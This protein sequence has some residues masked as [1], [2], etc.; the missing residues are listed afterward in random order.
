MGRIND[1]R[2][3]HKRLLVPSESMSLSRMSNSCHGRRVPWWALCLCL[4]VCLA[5]IFDRDLWTPDEPR[6]AAIS[7]EMS[8]TGNL[9]VPYLAGEPF[10]EK[11][12]LYFAIA[13]GF[14]RIL[15]PL[16]GNTGAIRLTSALWGLGAL[17]MTFLLARRLTGHACAVLTTAILATMWGFVENMHWIRVD[18]ALVFFVAAAVWSFAEVYFSGRQWF[19]LLAGLFTAGAF[20]SKGLIG[21]IFIGVAWT[22]MIIPWLTRQ[23]REKRKLDLFILPHIISLL[24]F[25]LLAGSWMIL[26]RVVGG[27]DLWHEWFWENHVGRLLGTAVSLSHRRAGR[28][29]Y[30]VQT[31]ATYG[32]PWFPLIFIWV[33]EVVRDLWKR[34]TVSPVRAFLLVWGLGSILLLSLSVTKRS[35]YLAPVFPAFAIMCAEV[36]QKDLPQWCEAFFVFWLGLCVVVLGM[37][38][39]SPLIVHFLPQFV[40]ANIADF[41]GIFALGNLLSGVGM[42]ACFYLLFQF[43]RIPAATCLAAATAMLYIGLFAVPA[44]AIDQEKSMKTE[45]H[46]FV[47]QIP[48]ARRPRVAG[49]EFSETMRGC[50]YY[51]CDWSVPQIIDGKRLRGIIVGQDREFD[52]VIIP[53]RKPSILD[54]LKV[55]FRVVAKGYPGAIHHKRGILWIEGLKRTEKDTGETVGEKIYEK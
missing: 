18:A 29:F 34:H 43:G 4:S 53:C 31:L 17:A 12:P 3:V 26:L 51:Y 33:G 20:L 15:G 9:V 54:L 5:G 47:A 49:W 38:A 48:T 8:R 45:M 25:V 1:F 30:Y 24:S 39:A 2:L 7:L 55:P 6:V 22:G 16:V 41:L 52:S 23:W 10:I 27:Q 19:C 14:V 37:L 21:P 40:P 42:T 11:P 32:L 28:P 35:I 13:A 36:F 44:K 46:L 50:F